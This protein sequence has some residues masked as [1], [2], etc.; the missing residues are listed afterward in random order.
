MGS[1]FDRLQRACFNVAKKTFGYL[2]ASWQRSGGDPV[3]CDVLFKDPTETQ[4]MLGVEYEPNTYI[5]EYLR[6]D[7]PGLYELVRNKRHQLIVIDGMRYVTKWAETTYDGKTVKI[8]LNIDD[9]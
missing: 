1:P 5:M 6:G 4:K 7:F 8:H 3:F 2:N 9:E